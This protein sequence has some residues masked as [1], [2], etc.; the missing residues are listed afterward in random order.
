ML[1]EAGCCKAVRFDWASVTQTIEFLMKRGEKRQ[2]N[3]VREV[4]RKD[5]RI[6]ASGVDPRGLLR[7]LE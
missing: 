2:V 4:R 7:G 6:F 3:R 1:S 5:F